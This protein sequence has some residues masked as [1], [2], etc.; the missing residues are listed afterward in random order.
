MN[1]IRLCHMTSNSVSKHTFLI[2][3]MIDVSDPF[4]KSLQQLVCILNTEVYHFKS[5][6]P[7]LEGTHS[8]IIK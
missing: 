4:I 3:I 1:A 2:Y 7:R 5:T 6:F 8:T